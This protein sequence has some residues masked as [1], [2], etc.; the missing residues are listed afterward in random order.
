M[1][2]V[3]STIRVFAWTME[4]SAVVLSALVGVCVGTYEWTRGTGG[5]GPHSSPPLQWLNSWTR[6]IQCTYNK[7]Q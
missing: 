6:P 5:S 7:V 1:L 4:A 2:G 3:H